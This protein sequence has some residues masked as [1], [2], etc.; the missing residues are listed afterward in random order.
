MFVF[1]GMKCDI[2]MMRDYL[3]LWYYRFRG[4]LEVEMVMQND[5]F[6]ISGEK[7]ME[8]VDAIYRQ[9]EPPEP[10][11]YLNTQPIKKEQVLL[12]A[13][14]FHCSDQV[15]FLFF[16]VLISFLD[17]LVTNKFKSNIARTNKKICRERI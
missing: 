14:D 13:I 3:K 7:W 8:W 17:E 2:E 6:L 12:D 4:D 10:I 16:T 5:V 11:S 1:A 15:E 9:M